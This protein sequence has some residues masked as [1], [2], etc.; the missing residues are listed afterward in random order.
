MAVAEDRVTPGDL[1]DLPEEMADVD[2]GDPASGQSPDQHEQALDVVPLEA[3][4]RFIHQEDARVGRQGAADLDHLPRGE[5]QVADASIGV[6]L[7]VAEVFQE[8]QGPPP[9]AGPIDPPPARRLDAEQNVL[10]HGQ[11]R[12]QGQLLM[13]QGDA[14]PARLERTGGRVR[15]TRDLQLAPIGAHGAG[16][17]VHQRG[18]PRAVL[19]DQRVHLAGVEREFHAVQRRRRPEP[20]GDVADLQDAGRRSRRAHC[21]VR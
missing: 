1:A 12:A 21:P 18:L 17:D 20:L 6:D 19:A 8:R 14:A 3:A 13:D 2:R 11:V 9:G 5:R 15:P 4:R 10:R 16:D 7:R